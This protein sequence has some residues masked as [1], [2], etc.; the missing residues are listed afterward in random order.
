MSR[1]GYRKVCQAVEA[2]ERRSYFASY[3]GGSGDDSFY[4]FQ[5]PMTPGQG[6]LTV[7]LAGNPP[8]DYPVN[9]YDPNPLLISGLGG[10]DYLFVDFSNGECAPIVGLDWDG[11]GQNDEIVIQGT[12]GPDTATISGNQFSTSYVVGQTITWDTKYASIWGGVLEVGVF[13]IFRREIFA[14]GF[15]RRI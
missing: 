13:C 10:D 2:L 15:P 1:Q 14:F 3:A 11:G 12:V 9:L 5:D 6:T 8:T 4:L 7:Q